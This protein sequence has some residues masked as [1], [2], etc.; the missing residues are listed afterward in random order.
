MYPSL[1]GGTSARHSHSGIQAE[2]AATVSGAASASLDKASLQ[3]HVS[4]ESFHLEVA[5]FTT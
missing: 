5:H 4:S 2:G 1:A 3:A